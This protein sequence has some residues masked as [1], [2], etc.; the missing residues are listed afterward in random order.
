MHQIKPFDTLNRIEETVKTAVHVAEQAG[1][2]GEEA[3]ATVRPVLEALKPVTKLLALHYP[4]LN[5]LYSDASTGLEA[6]K[7]LKAIA[8]DGGCS[9]ESLLEKL[10]SSESPHA[11]TA[12]HPPLTPKM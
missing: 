11:T 5:Q 2:A 3:A 4:E 12:T 1:K 6:L 10:A 8:Y 7:T 9:V